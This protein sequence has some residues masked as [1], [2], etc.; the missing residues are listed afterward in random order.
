METTSSWVNAVEVDS[1]ASFVERRAN[2]LWRSAWLLTGDSGLAEDLVQT[3]LAKT[4]DRYERFESDGQ[5]EAYLRT[6][7]YRTFVSWW[8]L[9]RWRAEVP[10]EE[11]AAYQGVA[12]PDSETRLDVMRALNTLPRM[13]R[14]VL[15]LRYFEDRSVDEVAQL[16]AIP[17]N[18]VKTHARRARLALRDLVELREEER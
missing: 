16:L 17:P 15:T 10:V 4:W 14:A 9:K 8:R 3:A 7:M 11:P 2:A 1:F 13:Q 5:F 6:T 18:T 12:P